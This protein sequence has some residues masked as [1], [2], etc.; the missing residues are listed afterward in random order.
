MARKPRNP[1][2]N[3]HPESV[4]DYPI[5]YGKPP[6]AT[7]FKK[8]ESGNESGRSPGSKNKAPQTSKLAKMIQSEGER[9][10][11]VKEAGGKL[12]KMS[13]NNM[14]VRKLAAKAVNGDARAMI[15]HLKL[16]MAADREIKEEREN[17]FFEMRDY[18]LRTEKWL[19]ERDDE[20]LPPPPIA[21]HPNDIVLNFETRTVT[22]LTL[23]EDATK[24]SKALWLI[25][26]WAEIEMS[27]VIADL[28]KET[29]PGAIRLCISS[30]RIAEEQMM[31]ARRC[32][33]IPWTTE[34]P[35]EFPDW[36]VLPRKQKPKP[37]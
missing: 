22:I 26:K 23:G 33:G 4:G 25:L 11:E 31:M 3:F 15:D 2:T 21:V 19:A 10:I 18:K 32:L 30:L 28:V 6:E 9:P 16:Q 24:M 20:G 5:G 14:I 27:A 34:S 12:T 13:I 37:S 8:Q 29:D 7:R 1:N 35:K 17:F 36:S